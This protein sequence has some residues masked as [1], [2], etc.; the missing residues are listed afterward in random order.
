MDAKLNVR[1][2]KSQNAVVPLVVGVT[3]VNAAPPVVYP[4]PEASFEVE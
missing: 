2:L 4:V 1:S 3:F